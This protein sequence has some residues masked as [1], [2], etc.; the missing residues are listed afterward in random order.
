MIVLVLSLLLS[1]LVA[2]VGH[3]VWGDHPAEL[4]WFWL[5]SFAG[6][7]IGHW[8]GVINDVALPTLGELHILPA[9]VGGTIGLFVANSIKV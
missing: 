5:L 7:L 2:S 3:L 9:T 6:F 8:L 4:A 1:G